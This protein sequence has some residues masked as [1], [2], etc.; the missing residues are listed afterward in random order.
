ME[1]IQEDEMEKEGGR[2]RA[3]WEWKML[4]DPK[5]G[6][7]PEGIRNREMAWVKRMP[8]RESGMFN[9]PLTE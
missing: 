3:E 8:F 4:R 5:T 7:I 2:K 6:K 1:V 9:N